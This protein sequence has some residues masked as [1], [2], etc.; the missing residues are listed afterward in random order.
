[1]LS[2]AAV[3]LTF[4]TDE[5]PQQPITARF[6]KAASVGSWAVTS[7][8]RGFNW[9]QSDEDVKQSPKESPNTIATLEALSQCSPLDFPLQPNMSDG[10]LAKQQHSYIETPEVNYITTPSFRPLLIMPSATHPEVSIVQSPMR[11]RSSSPI[12]SSPSIA[13]R[14]LLARTPSSPR[15]RRRSSQ[16]RVSLVAG[17]V[18]IA[19]LDQTLAPELQPLRRTNSSLSFHGRG[20][21]SG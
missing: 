11:S 5:W 8:G 6:Y 9:N 3:D 20:V 14:P 4:D 15:P 10:S 1:M 21:F 19:P 7:I 18:M 2:A 16:Q 13:V 17:R 12:V